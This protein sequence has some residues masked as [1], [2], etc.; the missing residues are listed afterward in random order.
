MIEPNWYRLEAI[1]DIDIKS[2]A[3][4]NALTVVV[5]ERPKDSGDPARYYAAFDRCDTMGD[6]VLIGEFGN[7]ATPDE[8]IAAYARKVSNKRI[9][10]N[11][12]TPQRRE[13]NVPRLR[14][15]A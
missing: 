2:F 13:M 15:P 10:V 7:G 1:P 12:H 4:A 3:E 14:W 11:A 9:V 8:A 6:G 5:R